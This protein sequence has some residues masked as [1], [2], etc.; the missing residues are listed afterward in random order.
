MLE[1]LPSDM[2]RDAMIGRLVR[3]ASAVSFEHLKILCDAAEG[4]ADAEA[5][6]LPTLR[7]QNTPIVQTD[8]SIAR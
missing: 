7:M 3:S 5:V 1:G 6:S 8:D 2:Q 4:W